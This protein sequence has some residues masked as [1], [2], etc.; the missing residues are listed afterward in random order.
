[1]KKG[2]CQKCGA[3]FKC[4]SAFI[5]HVKYDRRCGVLDRIY[6]CS[7]EWTGYSYSEGT[8]SFFTHTFMKLSANY[9]VHKVH[10]FEGEVNIEG[11]SAIYL[12][13]ISLRFYQTQ[14]E[15]TSRKI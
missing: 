14:E 10:E 6:H 5:Y 3:I 11:K 12:H 7:C 13:L 1:M 8:K 2:E 9:H 15:K 4:R